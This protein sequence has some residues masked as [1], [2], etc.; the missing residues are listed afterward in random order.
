MNANPDRLLWASDWPHTECYDR[1]P[2]DAD[3]V[4]LVDTWLPTSELRR[5]VLIDNPS[6]L[7]WN[8]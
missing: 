4:A 1:V 7:Y 8:P 2:D 3:L 5:K 6:R